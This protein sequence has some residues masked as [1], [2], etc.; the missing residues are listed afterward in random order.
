MDFLTAELKPHNFLM[1]VIYE[2]PLKHSQNNYRLLF[3]A[4]EIERKEQKNF[5]VQSEW[6]ISF[7]KTTK[8]VEQWHKILLVENTKRNEV[9][10][11]DFEDESN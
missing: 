5:V 4:Q 1:D 8:I 7:H 9:K 11:D 3:C 2:R 6:K 10:A